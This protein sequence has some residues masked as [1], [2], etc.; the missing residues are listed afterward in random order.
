[1]VGRRLDSKEGVYRPWEKGGTK[2][3]DDSSSWWQKVTTSCIE[4]IQRT[5][6]VSRKRMVSGV[7]FDT[8]SMSHAGLEWE[9]V[10]SHQGRV[11]ALECID[12]LY[13]S[14][15]FSSDVYLYLDSNAT[16]PAGA[17]N[18]IRASPR[19]HDTTGQTSSSPPTSTP[20]DLP[21]AP[22]AAH[23]KLVIAIYTSHPVL[24]PPPTPVPQPS[25]R[26]EGRCSMPRRPIS[27]RP[28]FP[29][30]SWDDGSQREWGPSGPEIQG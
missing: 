4:D 11:R 13:N 21:T 2:P 7:Q 6:R 9:H 1:M 23:P 10:L 15:Y 19:E 12:T 20:A 29:N 5:G 22:P 28:A 24:R 3:T 18:S 27:P 26:W 17:A 16:T 8:V 14:I 25:P 30:S